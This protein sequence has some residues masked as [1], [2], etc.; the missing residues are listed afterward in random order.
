MFEND[1]L[2]SV[3]Y[4]FFQEYFL[5]LSKNTPFVLVEDSI[6]VK[7]ETFNPTGSIKDRMISYIVDKAIRNNEINEST[8]LVEATSGNSGI[9]LSAIAST[10]GL[11]CIIFMPKNVS[12]ER[13][14]MIKSFGSR[15]F[16][17][18]D[19]NF[20][21]AIAQ[22]DLFL[23]KNLNSWSP[24]QFSNVQNVEYHRVFTAPEIISDTKKYNFNPEFI[25]QGSGTGG[26]IEGIRLYLEEINSSIKTAMVVPLEE[27]HQI[28][29]IGDGRN[30]LA[31]PNKVNKVIKVASSDAIKEAKQFAKKYGCMIGFSSGANIWAAKKLNCPV[32]TFVCDRGERYLS[33]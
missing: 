5:N 21:E 9:S 23:E 25:L 6:F 10:L 2:K 3:K 20:D 29:G 17:V 33:C 26:T 14:Q 28:Q 22:R 32:V 11:E 15:I 27:K 8:I 1:F 16:Y 18:E 7:F 19:Y 24:K 31:N 30:F 4:R 12:N 13:A